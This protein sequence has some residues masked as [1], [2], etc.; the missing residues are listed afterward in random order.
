MPFSFCSLPIFAGEK[1]FIAL[2][3]CND[4]Y[5][6]HSL[7]GWDVISVGL[8]MD[9]GALFQSSSN[10]KTS[11]VFRD[12]DSIKCSVR[13]VPSGATQQDTVEVGFSC[14]ELP[15]IS[16]VVEKP[17]GGFY[18]AIGMMSKGETITLSPPVASKM[19]SFV[20]VWKI[21][22]PAFVTHKEN[23]ICSYVGPGDLS[24][25]SIGSIRGTRPIDPLGGL[26]QRSFS[27]R[28]VNCGEK[29]FIG[30]GIVDKNYPT[31][32]LP[33]WEVCSVGYHAD[34]GEIFESSSDG[35]PTSSPSSAREGDVMQC[36]VNHIDN[37]QKQIRVTFL[38]N[39]VKVTDVTAWSPDTGFYFCF[40]MMSKGEVVQVLLQDVNIPFS[41][42]KLE[43]EEVW[44][45]MNA[46]IEHRGSGIC[47]YVGEEKVG[48]IRS[49]RPL[50]PFSSANFFEVKIV[51]PGKSCY[52]AIG[53]CSQ[54]YSIYDLPGWE[55][56]SVGYHAD[57]GCILQ[58]TAGQEKVSDPCEKGDVIRCTIEPVDGS[59]KQMNVVYHKNGS[60][61]GKAILWMP[62]DGHVFAQIGCMSQGE[63]I[64][65]SS[66]WQVNV[67]LKPDNPSAS[68]PSKMRITRPYRGTVSDDSDG[69][70]RF[71]D[72]HPYDRSMCYPGNKS[73]ED[74]LHDM[75]MYHQLH[76]LPHP[77][78]RTPMHTMSDPNPAMCFPFQPIDWLQHRAYG[79][80]PQHSS[81]SSP[82]LIRPGSLLGNPKYLDSQKS[83]PIIQGTRPNYYSTV[84]SSSSASAPASEMP[85]PSSKLFSLSSTSSLDSVPEGTRVGSGR[86]LEDLAREVGQHQPLDPYPTEQSFQSPTYGTSFDHGAL[87]SGEICPPS[88]IV[89]EIQTHCKSPEEISSLYPTG[90]LAD[91]EALPTTETVPPVHESI[92]LGRP[93][94]IVVQPTILTK[95][96]DK[97]FKI[98]HNV[99]VADEGS[100][101][102]APLQP[103]S[104][105]N[106]FIM[107]RLPLNEKCNYFEVEILQIYLGNNI[108][109]GVVWN[110]YP[111]YRLPGILEGSIAFHTNNGAILFGGHAQSMDT[112]CSIGDIIGCRITLKYKSEVTTCSDKNEGLVEV[113][114]FLNGKF[115]CMQKLFLPPNGF[116]P[117]IGMTGCGSKVRACSSILQTP[118]RYFETH[119]IP[120]GYLN[121]PMPSEEPSGWQCLQGSTID[122]DLLYQ[123][124]ECC[125]KP[126]IVQSN[127]PLTY[128]SDYFH[129]QLLNDISTYSV[130]SIGVAPKLSSG[131]IP[132][133][134]PNSLSYLPLLGFFMS[135]GVICWTI[136]EIVSL[137]L[138]GKGL[139]MGVGIEHCNTGTASTSISDNIPHK[140]LK[141][142][143]RM[144]IFFTLN[145]QQIHD[146]LTEVP[147]GGLYPTLAIERDCDTSSESLI[148]IE[149]PKRFPFR[150]HGLP[151]G[152]CRGICESVLLADTCSPGENI[153]VCT[154][155]QQEDAP[156]QAIQAAQP[157]SPS[158]PYF[159]VRILRGGGTYTISCGLA[160]YNYPLYMH[161]GWKTTSI[162]LHADDGNLFF[163]GEHTYVTIPP[164]YNGALL[165]CGIRFP[166]DN[167]HSAAEVF[168]TLN[169]RMVAS[170]LVKVP[171]LG[172]YP[173]VGMRTS[174]GIIE[175]NFHAQDPCPS[176]K[177]KSAIE[178]IE[179]MEIDGLTIQLM[180]SSSPGAIQMRSSSSLH[181]RNF[182]QVK[183]LSGR[184]GRIMVG[185]SASKS[186]PQNFLESQPFNASMMDICSGKLMLFNQYYKVR[187]VCPIL[188]SEIF[189]IGLEPIPDRNK[190][191]LFTTSNGYIVSYHEVD[192]QGA[193]D[194]YP[195]VMMVDSTSK[196]EVDLCSS[197]PK[198]SPI[199][200]GWATCVNLKL[201][202]L[203]MTHSS[204]QIKKRLPVGYAQAAVP[205]TSSSCYFEVEICSRAENKAIAIG[206]ASRTHSTTQ[207]IGWSEN[208]IG[209]HTDDGKLFKES[210]AGQSFGP[211]VYSGDTIGCGARLNKVCVADLVN[212]NKRTKVE[213]YFT[214]NGALLNT[215][216]MAIPHGGLFP[217][218]CLESPTES[219]IFHRY[220]S[221]PPV[222]N[223]VDSTNWANAY[224]VKQIGMTLSNSCRHKEINGGLPKAFCQARFPFSP[225]R[226]YFQV[227]ITSQ[228]K[229]D[230]LVGACVRIPVGCTS[231]NTH[232]V[233]YNN[234]GRIITRKG[235]QK[236][237]KTCAKCGHG[238][239]IGCCISFSNGVP[240]QA[241]IYINLSKV[242]TIH[243]KDLWSPQDLYPIIILAQPGDSV[244]P[245]LQ[246][247][248]PSRNRPPLIGWLRYER[249]QVHNNIVEY[250]HQAKSISDIGIAQISQPF[251]LDV[252]PY[253]E[254]EIIECGEC[255]VL[256][257]GAASAECPLNKLPGW[258][259]DTIAYHGDDGK[260]FYH[261][262]VGIPFAS[263]WKQRD[264]IGLG[265]R[266]PSGLDLVQNSVQV[267]F[268]KN[269]IELGHTTASLPPDGFFP[270]IGFHSVGLTV[271]I[272]L[273]TP[274]ALPCNMDPLR[275]Q[276]HSLCGIYMEKSPKGQMLGYRMGGRNSRSNPLSLAM[277]AQPFSV[278]MQYFEIELHSIGSFGIAVGVAPHDFPLDQYPGCCVDS[279]AYH[280][281]NGCLYNATHNGKVFGPV[282]HTGDVIGCGVTFLSNNT[283]HCSVF[284]TYNGMEIGRVRTKY[285]SIGLYPAIALTDSQDR[286]SVEFYETFK[287]RLSCSQVKFVNLLR[288][289]NCSYSEQIVSFKDSGNSGYDAPAMAQFSIPLSHDYNYYTTNIVEC[290]D[291]ILI[292]LAVKDYPLHFAPGTTSISLAYDILKGSIR[293][294]YDIENFFTVD[295]PVCVQGDSVGC[296][297]HFVDNV[298]TESAYVYF[299]HNNQLVHKISISNE[300]LLDDFYP[301]IGFLPQNKSSSVY[302]D[303]NNFNFVK[304]NVF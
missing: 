67:Q 78:M 212:S 61:I 114:F 180:S 100:L 5:P 194:I 29:C 110:H 83:E 26:A 293:A 85:Y 11:L 148:S 256:A 1:K 58:K 95:D 301:I 71:E 228:H 247:K 28:I 128:S 147:E 187:E 237:S 166:N 92:P 101:E 297:I 54:L 88:S 272:S 104:T 276:W 12:G 6:S 240:S 106:S 15:S 275:S 109:V 18:G 66:P 130:L 39:G 216:K 217:T 36:I 63:V 298:K 281:N 123:D 229:N 13:D 195:C 20:E 304:Q 271:K 75:F 303:W 227:E 47:C 60:F 40:G 98:L 53:A 108:A 25:H 169:R 146:I 30:M 119:P 17:P 266:Q 167:T 243:L 117:A 44:N 280:T 76:G 188:N 107:F 235:S 41:L 156:V 292:G 72:D 165:G 288:I 291:S 202:D 97:M 278:T 124:G 302:M 56:L 133:E 143:E 296:G 43:F 59:D 201:V 241:N 38:R 250:T 96:E 144:K 268:T 175:V 191:L 219:V 138:S 262:G 190:V 45:V 182:I 218:L 176:L 137:N 220:K 152:F 207:W 284:F 205:L 221:F 168:F 79:H 252:M 102:Y 213:V 139:L 223:L 14:N 285:P 200:Y 198:A 49:K 164:S 279:I 154:A 224:S 10:T 163:G 87:A 199:G 51:E 125:G 48:T 161:P 84:S 90:S 158:R 290:K 265:I 185:F 254:V 35:V 116:F 245:T 150:M 151:L 111:V 203:K 214:I 70:R 7:P 57:E 132:G 236:S 248:F 232:S 121:F 127:L 50:K 222:A 16:V 2:G 73:M 46:N 86:G 178:F 242:H 251:K 233:V 65:I 277:F 295:A 23:T 261:S 77:C 259:K 103:D 115:L 64:Q 136:P 255:C 274:N 183:C 129:I 238:D 62:R 81:S 273:G 131:A 193:A 149:F 4:S 31:N 300:F 155:L 171:Q 253:Y 249:V 140:P 239:I 287:P 286:V 55:D 134:I 192:I 208:S 170:R 24:E 42:P 196:L 80:N 294:V 68:Y 8:H 112:S 135:S 89:G 157:L 209:Y 32:L 118:E 126:A 211:K 160:G 141:A 113:Q 206:L 230:I 93:P 120:D 260:L 225:D 37:S 145:G 257:V 184:T 122:G 34:S 19:Q 186:C 3:V 33:G 299:T 204:T 21:S 27:L 52:I 283:K 82:V 269:G 181:E 246:M 189:G 74:F 177:F 91:V 179:N 174:E 173:T 215:Q 153:G 267:Y 264:V 172:L 263:T 289:N 234:T 105:N 99:Q 162:A 159:E 22:T 9:D 69:Q 197:W 142:V 231:P 244:I 94:S 270:I 210:S 258:C 226:P 282:A